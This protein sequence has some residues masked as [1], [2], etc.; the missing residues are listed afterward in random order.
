MGYE[1]PL[2]VAELQSG[3]L[4][5]KAAALTA[6]GVDRDKIEAMKALVLADAESAVK[7]AEG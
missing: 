1:K 5:D 2:R 3:A 4:A 6:S 7:L